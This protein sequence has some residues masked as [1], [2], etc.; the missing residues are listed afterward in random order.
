MQKF[1]N[2]VAH[3]AATNTTTAT[4]EASGS[5]VTVEESAGRRSTRVRKPR[6]PREVE[7][8]AEKK[9]RELQEQ[10]QELENH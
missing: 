1:N 8:L 3:F 10:I 6:V 2:D 7:S 5:N 4:N 9:A